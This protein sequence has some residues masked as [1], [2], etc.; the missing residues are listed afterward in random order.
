MPK[1]LPTVQITHLDFECPDTALPSL[2][3]LLNRC[4]ALESFTLQQQGWHEYESQYWQDL[5]QLYQ[6]LQSSRFSLRH[7][8]LTFNDWNVRQDAK[9]PTPSKTRQHLQT[10]YARKYWHQTLLLVTDY[11]RWSWILSH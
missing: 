11:E 4:S 3:H 1:D 5:R 6:S 2:P 10:A 9:T 7:L 8:S